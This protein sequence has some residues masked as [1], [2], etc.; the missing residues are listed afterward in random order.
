MES[1]SG[2]SSDSSQAAH[3][4]QGQTTVV[5]DTPQGGVRCFHGTGGRKG[6]YKSPDAI[7]NGLSS[8]LPCAA[9]STVTPMPDRHTDGDRQQVGAA[10]VPGQGPCRPSDPGHPHVI[11]DGCLFPNVV[12]KLSSSCSSSVIS[13]VYSLSFSTFSGSSRT[14]WHFGQEFLVGGGGQSCP[15]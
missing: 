8:R 10:N 4:P 3:W 14:N 1:R 2:D 6:R 15:L 11:L 9:H 5:Q 13:A 7:G 12:W